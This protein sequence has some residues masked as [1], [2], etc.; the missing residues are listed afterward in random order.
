M[1]RAVDR[2]QPQSEGDPNVSGTEFHVANLIKDLDELLLGAT[3]QALE[4]I[5][6][7]IV[8]FIKEIVGIDF[9]SPELFVISLIDVITTGGPVG[10]FAT[11]ILNILTNALGIGPVQDILPRIFAAFDGIDIT[12][13]GAIL[14]AIANAI[15]DA[16]EGLPVIGDIIQAIENLILSGGSVDSG[17]PYTIPFTI[18]G[19]DTNPLATFF[20]NFRSFF[21]FLDFSDIAFDIGAAWDSFLDG[22]PLGDALQSIQGLIQGFLN[23]AWQ[24]L[25]NDDEGAIDRTAYEV[26]DALKNIPVINVLGYGAATLVDTFTDILDNLWSALTRTTGTGKSMADVANAATD[27]A[28][29]ADTGV[30]IG[31]WNNAVLGLRN[32]KSLMSGIDETEEST[33]L[34]TDLYTG[35]S[36]PTYISATAASVPIAFWRATETAKKGFVSWLGKGFASITALYVDIYKFN[37]TTSEMELVHTSPSQ[38]ASVTSS[39]SYLVYNIASESDRI[40]VVSGDILGFAVRVV[41]AGTHLIGGKSAG[42]WLPDHPTV[43]PSRPAATRTGSGDLAFGSITYSSNVP[44]FGVGILSG[45]APPNFFAPRTTQFSEPGE[46]TYLIPDWANFIDG[47]YIGGGGGGCGGNVIFGWGGEGGY[48]GAWE[49]ET[50]VRGVDFPVD[51]TEI[52]VTVGAVGAAGPGNTPGGAGGDTIRADIDD[53]TASVTAAG[54]AAGNE[55]NVGHYGGDPAGNFTFNDVTYIGGTGGGAAPFSNGAAG[56]APGAGGGGGAGGTWGVAWPGG[57]GARGGAWM[58]ARNT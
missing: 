21:D 24:A 8:E 3:Q 18:G 17:I 6:V 45:D 52:T 54:G 39:W 51:A 19:S 20:A 32:N 5:K 46:S 25:V 37:F 49:G 38:I 9:S 34:L 58:T 30:Q 28:N 14:T 29:M 27:T 4:N 48:A 41:G 40:D 13:P 44:W 55:Q 23:T 26:A 33:F 11:M 10:E 47:V 22:T 57:I 31:E 7:A 42:A 36:D 1:P 50:L 35:G 12:N 56:T 43:V 2:Y 53:G 15:V 16:L